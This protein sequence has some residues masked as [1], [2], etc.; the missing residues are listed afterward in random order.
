[1]PV[2]MN[3]VSQVNNTQPIK[4]QPKTTDEKTKSFPTKTAVVVGTGLAALAAVGIYLATKGKG[5]KATQKAVTETVHNTQETAST[6]KEMTVDAF[7]QAGNKFNKGKAITSTGETFTGNITHQTKDGK[8]IVIEYENGVLKKSTKYDGKN[9]LTQKRYEHS[10][11]GVFTIFDNN[12][13]FFMKKT[14][15][16]VQTTQSNNVLIRKDVATGRLKTLQTKG[17]GRRDF[18]YDDK[19][20]LKTVEY[21]EKA[22][23]GTL[24]HDII[25]YSPEG[26]KKMRIDTYGLT[27]FYDKNGVSTDKINVDIH[28]RNSLYYHDL[29]YKKTAVAGGIQRTYSYTTPQGTKGTIIRNNKNVKGKNQVTSQFVLETPDKK[30]YIVSRNGKDVQ[31]KRNDLTQEPITKDSGE[32]KNVLAQSN[33]FMKQF[34]VKY[35]TALG[36]QHQVNEGLDEFEVLQRKANSIAVA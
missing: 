14:E 11:D 25:F 3:N 10:E 19:G 8:N 20:T 36:L 30:S 28:R 4:Q 35:K 1:M 7:K 16:R 2:S 6:V 34:F 9:V 13:F 18:Y 32:Y 12:D 22:K 15:G 23:D 31:V 27:E 24:I 33:D 17:Q 29:D 21:L 5:G 26:N